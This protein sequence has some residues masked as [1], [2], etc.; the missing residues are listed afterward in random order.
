MQTEIERLQQRLGSGEI[1]VTYGAAGTMLH[2]DIKAPLPDIAISDEE[3]AAEVNAMLD[4]YERGDY[5]PL[6]FNDSKRR[7]E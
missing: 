1:S 6:E 2:V 7:K 4:A 5:R 3:I